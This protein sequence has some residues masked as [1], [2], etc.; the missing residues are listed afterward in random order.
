VTVDGTDFRVN[1]PMHF[2]KVWYS[3]KFNHSG[4]RYEVAVSIQTGDIVWIHGPFPA[5]GWPDINI[6]RH[7]LLS[8]LGVGERVEADKGYIGE[9]P[10]H[11]KCPGSAYSTEEE[12]KMQNNARARHE[13]MNKRL[14]QWGSLSQQYRHSLTTHGDVFRAVAVITQLSFQHDKPLYEVEYGNTE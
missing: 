11:V 12:A 9:A 2:N 6:F 14:K 10:T 7:S 5:G 1:N 3:H 4:L 8:H 13:T